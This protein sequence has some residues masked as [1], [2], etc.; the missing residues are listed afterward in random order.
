MFKLAIHVVG[1]VRQKFTNH[2]PKALKV[3]VGW[4]SEKFLASVDCNNIH[5][6]SSI[7]VE[8]RLP[9]QLLSLGED[10]DSDCSDKL[11]EPRQ[12]KVNHVKTTL[13]GK[14]VMASTTVKRPRG[15]PPITRKS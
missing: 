4:T 9:L 12:N 11:H 15:R 13:K 8:C 5:A 2:Q 14:E 1:L 6:R 10:S 3:K 7:R